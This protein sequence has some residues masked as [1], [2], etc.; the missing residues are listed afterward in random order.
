VLDI[1]SPSGSLRG[2]GELAEQV[3]HARAR[4]PV[5]AVA[6]SVAAGAA[7]WLAR[8]AGEC[9]VTPS[10]EVGAIG[11][12]PLHEDWSKA[13][14]NASRR[15]SRSAFLLTYRSNP[16]LG[17]QVARVWPRYRSPRPLIPAATL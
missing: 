12:L 5:A 7:Y 2:V 6:N 14:G 11:V 10:G 9:Y 17:G 8:A 4:K 13:L 16:S 15:H 3:Y 1:D